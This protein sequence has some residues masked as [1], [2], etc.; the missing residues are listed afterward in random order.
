MYLSSMKNKSKKKTILKK[1]ISNA[2]ER[3]THKYGEKK[4]S[5]CLS[6][7]GVERREHI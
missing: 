6:E 7:V 5:L 2:S 3:G 1:N 4:G